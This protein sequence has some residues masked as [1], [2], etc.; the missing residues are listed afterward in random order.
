M[1]IRDSDTPTLDYDAVTKQYV[2]LSVL[3]IGINYYL[4]D[5]A[6][7]GVPAYKSLTITVPEL[8]ED[9]LD[10]TQN[11]AGDYEIGGW[12]APDT[13]DILKLGVYTTYLQAEK[14][15]GNIDVRLFYRLYERDSGGSETLIQESMI[16]DQVDLSLIH[17]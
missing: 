7:A 17:I 14:I 1:C 8:T 2:D 4:L 15:S 10:V 3:V 6:D 12:I 13:L 5:A 9:Y 11:T 16:S